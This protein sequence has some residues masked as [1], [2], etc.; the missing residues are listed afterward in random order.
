MADQSVLLILS[1]SGSL[2]SIF[3][4]ER[5]ELVCIFQLEFREKEIQAKKEKVKS[6]DTTEKQLWNKNGKREESQGI[7]IKKEQNY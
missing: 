1:S 3:D 7:N 5:E 6:Y 2:L 4:K